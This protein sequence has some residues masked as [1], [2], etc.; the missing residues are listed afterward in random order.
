MKI[1]DLYEKAVKRGIELDP[2]GIEEVGEEL[3]RTKKEYEELSE[4]KKKWFDKERLTNP[5]ADTRIL[6]GDPD[7][8]VKRLLVGVDMEVGEVLLAERLRDH[9]KQIDMILAHHPEGGAMA[10]L[11][12]VMGMQAGI[13]NRYG[14]PIHVAEDLMAERIREV[15]RRLKPANHTRAVDAA[16]LL[17][18]PFAC[19]HTPSDNAVATY[20]QG[21]FDKE[22]PRYVSDIIEILSSIPEYESAIGETIGP[23]MVVGGEKRRAGKIFVDMTGGTGG[24]MKIYD[25][26]STAGVSTIVGMHIGEEHRKEAEKHHI[27]VVLAG[28][29]SSDNLGLN[30]LL[31]E[32]LDDDV[33]VVPCSGFRRISRRGGK[34]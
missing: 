6:Y 15:G 11:Y 33:E 13:L 10:S 4:K 19:I 34:G 9:G 1:R 25:S 5:Y 23:G 21:I 14:V 18:I 7:K 29:I 30:L 17:D 27:G 26:L 12:D 28:H 24:S 31:D 20:L 8:D 22:E 2:R 3:E 16:R 32:I